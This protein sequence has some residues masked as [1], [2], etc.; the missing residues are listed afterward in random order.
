MAS[1]GQ[2]LD[3]AQHPTPHRTGPQQ[4]SIQPYTSVVLR[5]RNPTFVN[6]SFLMPVIE[7]WRCPTEHYHC[8]RKSPAGPSQTAHPR[9][10][11][12]VMFCFVFFPQQR[13]LLSVLELRISRIINSVLSCVTVLSGMGHS[14]VVCVLWAP[15]SISNAFWEGSGCPVNFIIT[16]GL[17]PLYIVTFTLVVQRQG[18]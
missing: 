15:G 9:G 5:W 6:M 13:L 11:T 17:F 2:R 3:V 16:L 10:N 12:V 8:L 18:R 1:P 14:S 7:G 4:R